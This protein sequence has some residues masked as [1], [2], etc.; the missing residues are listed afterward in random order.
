M[1]GFK[2]PQ[3]VLDQ[4][5]RGLIH[6]EL[7]S[8]AILLRVYQQSNGGLSI[9]HT[10]VLYQNE[11]KE[12][13]G[14]RNKSKDSTEWKYILIEIINSFIT[15]NKA[16]W[17]AERST[18]EGIPK[19]YVILEW[20]RSKTKLFI[21]GAGHIGQCVAS[22]GAGL[23]YQV[24]VVDDRCDFASRLRFPDK[25]IELAVGDFSQ[26]ISMLPINNQSAIVIVTRGHQYDEVCLRSVIQ[27]DARY[28]GMIGSKKRVQAIFTKLVETGLAPEQ[29]SRVKAPIGLQIGAKT[30][31]EIGI[32]ITAE[33]IACLNDQGQL[34][35]P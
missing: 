6:N 26:I 35:Q 11:I 20:V 10:Q 3:I 28:I 25:H 21:F 8:G 13:G 2:L 32:A 34:F 17:F 31:Q 23:G 9:L 1:I 16:V 18:G 5:E 29:L 24:T 27:T 12:Q 4:L 14:R 33:I 7:G 15:S 22:L 19:H 30:P